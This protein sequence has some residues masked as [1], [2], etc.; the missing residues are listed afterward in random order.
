MFAIF[1]QIFQYLLNLS[2]EDVVKI[3]NKEIDNMDY[4]DHYY[5]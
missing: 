3:N 4:F 2:D 5:T 1:Q